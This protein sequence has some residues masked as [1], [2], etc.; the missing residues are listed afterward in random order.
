MRGSP[1]VSLGPL[2]F[3]LYMLPLSA[4]FRFHKIGL[5]VY[6]DDTQIY[7]SF[8]CDDPLQALDKINVCISDIRRRMILNKLKINDAKTE[9]IVF[10]SPMLKHDLNDL[11]VNVGGNLMKP[12]EKVRDLGVIL[13]QTLSFDDQIIAIC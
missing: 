8:K 4:I 2:K 9:F 3:C 10:R 6:A 11:T 7:V 12:S 13:D 5:H 1:R